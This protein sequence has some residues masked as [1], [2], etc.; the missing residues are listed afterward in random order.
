MTIIVD[1]ENPLEV[2]KIYTGCHGPDGVYNNEIKFKV[3][4][5]AIR[6]DYEKSCLEFDCKPAWDSPVIG[7]NRFIYYEVSFD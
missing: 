3:L 2:G 4:K 5:E 1:K 7:F 6:E